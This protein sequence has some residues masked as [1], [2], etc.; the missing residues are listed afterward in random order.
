MILPL[1][2]A[3]IL[4]L[5]TLVLALLWALVRRLRRLAVR[6]FLGRVFWLHLGLFLV[7]L[8]FSVPAFL[9]FVGSRWIDTRPDE[10]AYAGPRILRDGSW[11]LQTRVSLRAEQRGEVPVDPDVAAA[12][13]GLAQRIEGAGGVMLR[14]FL[15]PP[16]KGPPRATVLMVHGL[17]R[18]AMELEPVGSMLRDLGCEVVLLEQRNHGGSGRARATF[19]VAESA[20][21]VAVAAWLRARPDAADRPLL[22][23]GVSLG[24]LSVALAAPRIPH[25]AGLLL[26]APLEDLTAAAHRMMA[27]TRNEGRRVF[28]L[29]NPWRSLVF[30]WLEW[31]SGFAMADVRPLAALLSLPQ[32]L[33]VLVI[34]AGEDD[35]APEETVQ[36]LFASLPVVEGRKELW[37]RAASGHGSVW[38][39]D[40]DG[41][42]ERLRRWLDRAAG[43]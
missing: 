5:P 18:S 38:H 16:R 20:D 10:R 3:G 15:V 32:D 33:P 1:I 28:E 8:F 39:D 24:T 40:P 9:G 2:G 34:G 14:A 17:F 31:W 29:W 35:V 21:V 6:T 22:L 11:S 23:C 41:Y 42:R 7:H 4:L 19:G 13:A 26:D 30:A 25:L 43:L 37:I 12:A 36:A 27:R